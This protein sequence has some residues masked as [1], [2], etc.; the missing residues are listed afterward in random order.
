M[1]KKLYFMPEGPVN[2]QPNNES[3]QEIGDSL[4]ADK[5]KKMAEMQGASAPANDIVPDSTYEPYAQ[6]GRNDNGIA[7]ASPSANDTAP[8]SGY[9]DEEAASDEADTNADEEERAQLDAAQQEEVARDLI[10]EQEMQKQRKLLV[11][12][13]REQELDEQIKSLEKD[14]NEFKG[15]NLKGVLSIFQPGM[16]LIIDKLIEEAKKEL[17][18]MPDDAKV[19]KLTGMILLAESLIAM[20]TPFKTFAGFLDAA[21]VDSKSCLRLSLSSASCCFLFPLII[22]LL[23]PLYIPFLALIF[24]IGKIPLFKGLLTKNVVSMIDNLKKQKD[25]W[26]AERA[27]IRLRAQLKKQKQNIAKQKQQI[28]KEQPRRAA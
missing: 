23:S 28:S 8:D 22:I 1:T 10:L 15:S 25:A 4:A 17:S 5:A 20:L 21:F 26:I 13:K 27:R 12:E 3:Q 16:N 11:V 2:Q 24:I 7:D 18:K 14:L 19:A 9:E 6:P